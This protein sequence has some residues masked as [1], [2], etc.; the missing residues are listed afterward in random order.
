MIKPAYKF[1]AF[2][3]LRDSSQIKDVLENA[4]KYRDNNLSV[5][6]KPNDLDYPR[7]AVIIAN[8]YVAKAVQRNRI[9]RLVRE[10]FRLNQS[11]ITGYD[12]VVFGYRGIENFSN[13]KLLQ[14]LIKNWQRFGY[15]PEK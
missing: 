7:L 5:F 2:L 11:Q 8:K 3:R 10:S 14:C 12:I 15:Y 9:K 1:P 4:K 13:I 6:V